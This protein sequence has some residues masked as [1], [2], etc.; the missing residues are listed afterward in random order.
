VLLHYYYR[1]TTVDYHFPFFQ[2]DLSTILGKMKTKLTGILIILSL[3]T[4]SCNLDFQQQ[5]KDLL[6]SITWT[7]EESPLINGEISKTPESH[8]TFHK[9]G[10]YT[11]D[12][13]ETIIKGQW[14]WTRRNEIYLEL[15]SINAKGIQ[16]DFDGKQNYYIR[17]LE[18]SESNL[19]TLQ[20]FE[21]DTWDS[22]FAKE[23]NYRPI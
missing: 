2:F 5:S 8:Y 4:I 15:K 3:A 13:G 19:K 17:I 16:G 1:S 10:N 20:R 7:I 11:L 14:K 21:T 12:V 23:R 22:G 9:N 18:V 6:T